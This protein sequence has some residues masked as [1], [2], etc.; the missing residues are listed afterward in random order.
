MI[1][2]YVRVSTEDQAKHGY[3]LQAQISECRKKAE[4]NEVKE[5]IDDGVSGELLDRPGL[6]RLREDIRS[7]IIKKVI[8]LDPDRLSR[9][10]MNQLIITD[11]FDKKG[12]ELIFVNGEYTKTPEGSLFYNMRGAIA[13]FEKAKIKERMGRGRKEKAKSGKVLR[14]FNIYGYK[15]IK[16][17]C[18]IEIKN[19][20]AEI[21]KLIFELFVRPNNLVKGINGIAKYLT[22]RNVPTKKG[23]NIWHRQVVR[24]ILMNEVYTG[25]FYQNRWNTEGMFINKHVKKEERIPMKERPREEWIP[26][27][28]PRIIDD[29][30]FYRAQDLLKLSRRR[31]AKQSK[32]KY[33]LS[34]LVRCGKCGNTMTGRRSTNWGKAVFEYT[35]IKNTSGAKNPGC[36][37]KVKAEL[38]ENN[39]WT[40]IIEWLNNPE[41][42]ASASQ[43]TPVTN[44]KYSQDEVQRLQNEI[45]KVKEGRKRLLN[46]FAEGL[47]ISEDE[48]RSSIKQLKEKEEDLNKKLELAIKD[49]KRHDKMNLS[50]DIL[51]EAADY[52]LMNGGENLSFEDK[53]VILNSIIKEIIIRDGEVEILTY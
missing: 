36:G 1:G 13:E 8:C 24:Q 22:E 41:E 19:D 38:L 37:N 33:L 26:V 32:N 39:V 3:S 44:I 28:C 43:E 53:K 25:V 10:L 5:Y 6:S 48:I 35:D 40:T 52:Y 9:K 2:I 11:E 50:N 30:T 47:D 21:V 15:Y 46:L 31:W 23:G 17:N 20:E 27:D 12:V 7:G 42:I 45:T 49:Q 51:K 4:S 18:T 16:E 29:E 14:D 34:G